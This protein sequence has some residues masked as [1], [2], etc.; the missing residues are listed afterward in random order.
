MQCLKNCVVFNFLSEYQKSMP[1]SFFPSS[2]HARPKSLF[3]KKMLFYSLWSSKDAIRCR[4]YVIDW[5]FRLHFCESIA[6]KTPQS[7]ETTAACW[8]KDVV[9]NC[10]TRHPSLVRI[11]EWLLEFTASK[12][13]S[14]CLLL[15]STGM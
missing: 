15:K 9:I 1:K 2:N 3:K 14:K 6:C 8:H 5:C 12:V 13:P 4:C 11:V 10:H 7:N